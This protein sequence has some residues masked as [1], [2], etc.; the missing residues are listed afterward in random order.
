MTCRAN[1]MTLTPM[2]EPEA[3]D[4]RNRPL[5]GAFGHALAFAVLSGG[6]ALAA[7][8]SN[9]AGMIMSAQGLLAINPHPSDEQIIQR[10]NGNVCRCGTYPRI[11]A[12]IRRAAAGAKKP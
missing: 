1:V 5:I 7:Y 10:M 3:W 4:A 12:A 11:M 2:P 6:V 8:T 9:F